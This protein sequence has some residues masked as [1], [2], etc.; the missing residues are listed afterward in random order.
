MTVLMM[1][2]LSICGPN[3]DCTSMYNACVESKTNKTSYESKIQECIEEFE[4]DEITFRN[5]YKG[6]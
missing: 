1:L 5:I 4:T 6:E 3:A 2:L